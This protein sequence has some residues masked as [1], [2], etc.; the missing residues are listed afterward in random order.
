[1]KFVV[2]EDDVFD[3]EWRRTETSDVGV[4]HDWLSATTSKTQHQ[5][6]TD[7][8]QPSQLLSDCVRWS[9]MPVHHVVNLSAALLSSRYR[10]LVVIRLAYQLECGEGVVT[11]NDHP[12]SEHRRINE[13]SRSKKWALSDAPRRYHYPL[14]L[15]PA[16]YSI[17]CSARY[18]D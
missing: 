6:L 13:E 3:R 14:C 16:F 5:Q 17:L 10:R 9:R 11:C 2:T 8:Y 18:E 12:V 1:M 4:T 7:R 15:R